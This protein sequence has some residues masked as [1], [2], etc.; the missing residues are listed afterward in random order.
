MGFLD[1]Q[2]R[3]VDFSLTDLGREQY[4][5]GKLEF[6]YYAFFDDGV[7]YEPYSTAE[8]DDDGLE[9]AISDQ[10][11]LEACTVPQA[12]VFHALEPRFHLFTTHDVTGLLPMMVSPSS[13]DATTIECLQSRTPA[14]FKRHGTSYATFDTSVAPGFDRQQFK[15]SVFLSSSS[16]LVELG[17]RLD[18]RLRRCYDPFLTVAVDDENIP[19]ARQTSASRM[20]LG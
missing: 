8:L 4:A 19:S 16:G 14:G 15:L 9:Q 1:N 20:K 18:S 13:S 12:S 3:V 7:D 5:A 11:M 2:S 10:P 6:V 17:P